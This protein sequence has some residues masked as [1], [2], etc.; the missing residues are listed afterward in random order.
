MTRGLSNE[1][2]SSADMNRLNP[3][4]SCNENDYDGNA[5]AMRRIG[6]DSPRP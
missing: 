1:P 6:G 2:E 5:C 3:Q 4:K